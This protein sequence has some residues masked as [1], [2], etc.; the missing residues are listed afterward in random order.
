MNIVAC[1]YLFSS[2]LRCAYFFLCFSFFRVFGVD[3]ILMI[4]MVTLKLR[5]KKVWELL[6]KGML[7][8]LLATR[9]AKHGFVVEVDGIM[10]GFIM[11]FVK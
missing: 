5:I 8:S 7:F 11:V 4:W 9:N 2:S 3:A 10:F 1:L 6:K